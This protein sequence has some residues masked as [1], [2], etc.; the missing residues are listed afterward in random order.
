MTKKL[1]VF[2][3]IGLS[4]AWVGYRCASLAGAVVTVVM[5]FKV[6]I[7]EFKLLTLE[8]MMDC[9]RLNPYG[10]VGSL[11]SDSIIKILCY[12]WNCDHFSRMGSVQINT[13]EYVWCFT[14]WRALLPDDFFTQKTFKSVELGLI[15]LNM[16]DEMKNCLFGCLFLAIGL[17]KWLNI[18][19]NWLTCLKWDVLWYSRGM[20]KI[21]CS[22]LIKKESWSWWLLIKIKEW[23]FEN[24][25]HSSDTA[26][27][28][29]VNAWWRHC[30]QTN[31][32]DKI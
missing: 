8:G 5:T 11:Q 12:G 1:N 25:E 10:I 22:Q 23:I 18:A 32:S 26:Q 7:S 3:F 4:S 31:R 27:C 29:V 19:K 15:G 20:G 24:E 17:K 2:E 13:V 14:P 6:F 28:V 9:F 21:W 30:W 16:F